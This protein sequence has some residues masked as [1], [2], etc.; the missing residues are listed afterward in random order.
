MFEK[1]AN[2]DF[3]I[4]KDLKFE[5][6]I[7]LKF[8]AT[9]AS[10]PIAASEMP[11]AMRHFPIAFSMADP[12]IPVAFM[13]LMPDQNAFINADGAWEG[14]Y[15]PA[16][17]RRFPFI[18][19]NTEDADKFTIMF[20]TDAPELNTFTGRPLYEETGDMA[21]AL[22]EVVEFL[23]GFQ[24]EL[25]ATETLIQPLLEKDVL[26]EQTISVNQPDGTVSKFEGFR[27]VDGARVNALDDATL[28]AWTRSGLMAIIYAHLHSLEN[29]RYLAERQGLIDS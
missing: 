2:L 7:N 6:S 1:F 25:L 29:V 23:Q 14:D 10:A 5:P 17:I 15:L 18:L 24:N 20:D 22:Q 26:T 3:E 21:P 16:H 27:A 12:L 11:M 9:T 8:A 28:A 13:S 19:G 4:H